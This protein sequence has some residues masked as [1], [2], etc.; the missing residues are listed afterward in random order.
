MK[1][2][3]RH[4]SR[5]NIPQSE[6][7]LHSGCVAE[8]FRAATVGGGER[9]AQVSVGQARREIRPSKKLVE[10]PGVEAVPCAN[11][12]DDR[13]R[14][15]G[16]AESVPKEPFLLKERPSR[17]TASPGTM[18]ALLQRAQIVRIITTLPAIE[19]LA[20]NA[21]VTAGLGHVAAATIEIHPGQPDPGFPTQLHP[22][23]CIFC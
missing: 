11:R 20:A 4:P 6:K 21:E 1:L 7:F 2:S 19:R 10:E 23:P 18:T 14:H 3:W 8:R 13:Y 15:G 9:S 5:R 16:C 17:L 12:I 22:E